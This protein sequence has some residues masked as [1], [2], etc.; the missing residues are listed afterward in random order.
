MTIIH[1]FPVDIRNNIILKPNIA[2]TYCEQNEI[3]FY[4]SV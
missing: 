1:C 2:A 3:P 4:S